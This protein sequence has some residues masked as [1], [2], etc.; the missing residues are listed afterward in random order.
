VPDALFDNPRLA[1]VYDPLDPDRGDLDVYAAIVRELGARTVLDIGC[2]TGTF[3]CMLAAGGISVVGLDPAAASLAVARSKPGADEVR[4]IHGY[5]CELPPLQMDLVTMTANVAQV[6]LTDDD[7][8]A[9]L[10]AAYAA[11]RPGGWL[12]FETRDP[13]AQAWLEWN[14]R[15]SRGRTQI[16]GVGWVENWYEVTAVGD[17]LVSFRGTIVFESDGQV[18]TSDSTLRFRTRDEVTQSLVRTGFTFGEVREAP[19]RPGRE[20]VFF[21]RRP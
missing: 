21:A 18:L 9:T 7:W 20:M 1:A 6:F 17:S 14:P 10:R 19:D 11:L 16:P 13:A 2:G 5:A 15:Q 8:D 4:W 12:V 3:A